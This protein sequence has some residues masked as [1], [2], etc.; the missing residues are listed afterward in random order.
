MALVW[1]LPDEHCNCCS[2][3]PLDDPIAGRFV[4]KVSL[5]FPKNDELEKHIIHGYGT[6]NGVVYARSAVRSPNWLDAFPIWR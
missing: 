2:S 1:L 6:E 5:I 3:Q 4:D